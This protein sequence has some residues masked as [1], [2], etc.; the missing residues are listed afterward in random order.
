MS[1]T[2]R[3]PRLKTAIWASMAVRRAHQ[4]GSSGMVLRRG[5]P[6]A[7]GVLAVLRNRNGGLVVL[8]QVRRMDGEAAW[9]RATGA[10][11]VDQ[12]TADAYVARQVSR[13]P[14]LWVLE[15][16][17]RDLTPPFEAIIV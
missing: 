10:E 13:D 16:D 17:T 4:T 15:F 5:D 8:S 7:G 2:D 1:D 9:M 3:E 6:D 12:A 14:D 11:P